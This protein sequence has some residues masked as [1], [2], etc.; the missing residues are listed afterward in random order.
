MYPLHDHCNI[1]FSQKSIEDKFKLIEFNFNLKL[2]TIDIIL[3]LQ[4]LITILLQEPFHHNFLSCFVQ[5]YNFQI[6]IYF[7]FLWKNKA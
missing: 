1:Y 2:V 5:L 4:Y 3:Q 7:I 6:T